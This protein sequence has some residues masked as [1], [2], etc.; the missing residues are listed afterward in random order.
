MKKTTLLLLLLFLLTGNS[1]AK[2]DTFTDRYMKLRKSEEGMQ[3]QKLNKD[4]IM[5]MMQ[6]SDSTKYSEANAKSDEK[7]KQLFQNANQMIIALDIDEDEMLSFREVNNLVGKYEDILSLDLDDMAIS[8]LAL[9]K[10]KGIEELIVLMNMDEEARIFF[11]IVFEKPI[12]EDEWM[13]IMSD[14]TFN[15]MKMSDILEENKVDSGNRTEKWKIIKENGLY[16]VVDEEG[17]TLIDAEYDEIKPFPGLSHKYLQ[18]KQ[19]G[20]IGLGNI[21]GDILL[22]AEY[23]EIKLIKDL[24]PIHFQV[25]QEGKYGLSDKYGDF[26]LDVEYKKIKVDKKKKQATGTDFDGEKD[27]VDL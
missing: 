22:D 3:V 25:K 6:T 13:N 2:N 21:E 1:Y 4:D 18:L 26:L 5:K 14:L 7:N 17:D 27:T 15:G 10:K 8:I 16:G 23:D 24:S 9:S 19:N 12:K 20:K 11:D